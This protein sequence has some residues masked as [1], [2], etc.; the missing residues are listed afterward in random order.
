MCAA[1]VSATDPRHRAGPGGSTFAD[2]S[3]SRKRPFPPAIAAGG[4]DGRREGSSWV[5][6]IDVVVK[7]PPTGASPVATKPLLRGP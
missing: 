3:G 7:R 5:V 4:D 6:E 1:R 2:Y